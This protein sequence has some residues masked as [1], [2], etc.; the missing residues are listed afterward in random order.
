[1]LQNR[2]QFAGDF[3]LRFSMR[4]RRFQFVN[5]VTLQRLKQHRFGTVLRLIFRYWSSDSEI[6]KSSCDLPHG[7]ITMSYL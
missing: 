4:V 2:R 3:F 1:M 6:S 5:N 7:G